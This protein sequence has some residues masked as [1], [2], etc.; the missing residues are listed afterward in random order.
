MGISRSNRRTGVMA[1]P[2]KQ[3]RSST[4]R[5]NPCGPWQQWNRGNFK[6]EY[7][8][9]QAQHCLCGRNWSRRFYLLFRFAVPC[10]CHTSS[11]FSFLLT[12]GL[13]S[14]AGEAPLPWSLFG[15]AG[16]DDSRAWK[17][18]MQLYCLHCQERF[19]TLGLVI[20]GGTTLLQRF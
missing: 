9:R 10:S 5:C 8:C 2:G 4:S 13:P 6:E 12:P 11:L 17:K 3:V 18:G 15:E 20:A 1:V 14:F 16:R 19:R 7:R